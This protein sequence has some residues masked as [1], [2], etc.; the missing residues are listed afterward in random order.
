MAFSSNRFVTISGWIFIGI[1]ND[2]YFVRSDET[3]HLA[4]RYTKNSGEDLRCSVP[5]PNFPSL[6]YFHLCFL[7][8]SYLLSFSLFLLLS[9][10]AHLIDS[11]PLLLF[12][13]FSL[14]PSV[15]HF[16]PHLLSF[17]PPLLLRPSILFHYFHRF[18]SLV[19]YDTRYVFL[20]SYLY[21][22]HRPLSLVIS[23]RFALV[24]CHVYACTY[25]SLFVSL[26]LAGTKTDRTLSIVSVSI[27]LGRVRSNG[28]DESAQWDT[29][30]RHYLRRSRFL[31]SEL[32][33]RKDKG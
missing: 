23:L 16:Y 7:V 15:F 25:T 3:Q 20:S 5:L 14:F 28:S 29:T 31:E 24:F 9:I 1:G 17:S 4:S 13:S 22:L 26:Y 32:K 27:R 11:I 10:S 33:S 6:S 21:L 19:F 18:V 2:G 12:F 30:K 8:L